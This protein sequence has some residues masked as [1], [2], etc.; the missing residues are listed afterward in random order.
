[1]AGVARTAREDVEAAVGADQLGVGAKD[2]VTKAFHAISAHARSEPDRVLM[3][4]DVRAAHQSF[5]RAAAAEALRAH[6]PIL[7][8]PFEAWYGAPLQHRW[9][10]SDGHAHALDSAA[11]VDQGDPIASL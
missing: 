7:A 8:C 10:T 2:G 11:G 5:C 9:V 4:L 6:A 1:M 3:A